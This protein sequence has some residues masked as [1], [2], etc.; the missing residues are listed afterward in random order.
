MK[1]KYASLAF[2][3]ERLVC[4]AMVHGRVLVLENLLNGCLKLNTHKQ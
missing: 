4:N 3:V 2:S 1:G